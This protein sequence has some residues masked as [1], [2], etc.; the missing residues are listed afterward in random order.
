MKIKE[1][2]VLQSIADKWIV[3]DTNSKSVNFNKVLALNASGKFLWEKL[4]EGM[5]S[6]ALVSALIKQFGIAQATAEKDVDKFIQ[7]LKDLGCMD[8]ES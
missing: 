4:E 6:D 2:Y 3:I 8:N 5:K 7:E 1:E